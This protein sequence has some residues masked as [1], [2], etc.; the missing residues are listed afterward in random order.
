MHQ[1]FVLDGGGLDRLLMGQA[2]PLLESRPWLSP[3]CHATPP[4]RPRHYSTAVNLTLG[5]TAHCLL[6]PGPSPLHFHI[7][8]CYFTCDRFWA[9]IFQF[10]VRRIF[11]SR[12]IFFYIQLAITLNYSALT[13]GYSTP[14]LDLTTVFSLDYLR[15]S[16]WLSLSFCYFI[17]NG[18]LSIS[19]K[20][21][22]I[23]SSK[24]VE[25]WIGCHL[26]ITPPSCL[27]ASPD[28]AASQPTPLFRSPFLSPSSTRSH[29][30]SP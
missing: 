27:F 3:W 6:P 13:L 7:Q 12:F 19:S 30:F 24:S 8:L 20:N 4:Y 21:Y 26:C 1:F 10:F 2:R 22:N 9:P 28:R 23:W 14:N 11:A 18:V 15:F 29:M 16:I 5:A 25:R 17:K